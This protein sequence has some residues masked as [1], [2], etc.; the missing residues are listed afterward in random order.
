[1]IVAGYR[2]DMHPLIIDIMLASNVVDRAAHLRSDPGALEHLRRSPGGRAIWVSDGRLAVR[3]G[4]LLE[5]ALVDVPEELDCTFLGMDPSQRPYVMVR[6]TDPVDAEWLGLREVGPQLDDVAGS[7]AVMAVALDHWRARTT[8]CAQCGQ[9]LVVDQSGWALRCLADDTVVFPRTDPA[10]IV[11]VIGSDDRVALG[12]HV[13]WP[14]G[15]FSTFAGF[16]EAGE[17]AEAAAIREVHEE[18]GLRLDPERLQYLGS[19]PWPFPQSLMLGYHAHTDDTEF[20]L[21][22]TE[23]EEARW[24]TREQLRTEIAAGSVVLPPEMSISRRLIGR[25]LTTP[26]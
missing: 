5:T 17:S 14:D 26:V 7:L 15:R 1:M 11:L 2:A 20:R 12:R 4:G 8:Y 23:I 21:D 22:P 13:D 9:A 16:V 25:W 19:Q 10:A 18:S 3:A 24:F 6:A